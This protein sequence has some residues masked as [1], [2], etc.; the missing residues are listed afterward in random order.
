MILYELNK[1]RAL[2]K[3]VF[4]ENLQMDK[5]DKWFI[6]IKSVRIKSGKITS[7]STIIRSDMEKRL[8]DY[9]NKGWEIK[10]K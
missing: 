8:E 10:N 2:T 4:E 6:D 7:L 3:I 9:L 5:S 1:K